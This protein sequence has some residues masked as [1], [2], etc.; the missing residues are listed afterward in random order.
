M[1]DFIYNF[2]KKIHNRVLESRRFFDIHFTSN[3]KIYNNKNPTF[4]GGK[5]M[6]TLH[7][8]VFRG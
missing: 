4:G 2:I 3:F 1:F 8:F 7:Y 5:I 6:Y